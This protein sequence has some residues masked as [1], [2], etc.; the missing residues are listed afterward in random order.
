MLHNYI[1]LHI[2]TYYNIYIVLDLDVN[3]MAALF[4]YGYVCVCVVSAMVQQ[5]GEICFVIG[6]VLLSTRWRK[7]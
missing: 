7:R 3:Q 5:A 2:T 6:R 4:F 1:L